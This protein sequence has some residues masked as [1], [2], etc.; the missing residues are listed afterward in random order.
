MKVLSV[1]KLFFLHTNDI[2]ENKNEKWIV[3]KSAKKPVR[4]KVVDQ[5][6]YV[7]VN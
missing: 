7:S 6:D 1:A 5:E 4:K 3:E 2:R